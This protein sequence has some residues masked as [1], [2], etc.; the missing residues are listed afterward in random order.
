MNDQKKP[1]KKRVMLSLEAQPYEELQ[2]IAKKMGLDNRWFSLEVGK[3][4]KGLLPIMTEAML[5]TE[6]G[7]K[8]SEQEIV[9]LVV[10]TVEKSQ[11]VKL[12]D[13]LKE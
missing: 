9:R 6:Q 4:V 7:R 12:R 1:K 2:A 8:M 13:F 10:D 11:G 3:L 5:L